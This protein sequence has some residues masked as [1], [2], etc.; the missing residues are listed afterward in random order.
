MNEPI[1]NKV[2]GSAIMSL[3]L[4]DYYPR[5]E[6][7]VFDLKPHLFMELILK[8]KEFRAALLQ[9]DWSVYQDK[10]VA[11]ECSADSIIP[12]WAYMLVGS[13]LQPYAAD[14]IFG[15]GSEALRQAFISNLRKIDLA[16]FQDQRVVIKGCGELNVAEYAYLEITRLLRPIVKSLMYGEP[17]STVPI[18]KQKREVGQ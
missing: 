10:I 18:Y 16:Q 11:V 17:C 4:E 1:V 7:I 3:D 15:S 2:A 12:R 14:I 8:E 13:Y 9:I 5:E 6:I